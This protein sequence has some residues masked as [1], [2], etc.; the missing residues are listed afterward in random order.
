MKKTLLLLAVLF[1]AMTAKAQ[2]YVGGSI[3]ANLFES[4][5]SLVFSPDFGYTFEEAPI[6]VGLTTSLAFY[7]NRLDGD[8]FSL[9]NIAVSPYLRYYC[10]DIER[11]GFFVDLA[12]DFY[13]YGDSGFDVGFMPGVSFNLTEH[14]SAEFSYGWIGYE[15][16]D[17]KGFSI[18]MDASTS[19]LSFYYNF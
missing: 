16:Y 5:N 17:E 14:W 1:V 10:Y 6:G 18:Q 2:W 13:V 11:F 19:K 3:N 4:Y 12:G 7:Q 15:Q 8:R 9:D